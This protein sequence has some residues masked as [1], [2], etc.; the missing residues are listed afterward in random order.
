MLYKIPIEM[1]D[2]RA[3]FILEETHSALSRIIGEGPIDE[4]LAR[5]SEHMGLTEKPILKTKKDRYH[6]L[7]QLEEDFFVQHIKENYL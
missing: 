5:L 7:F 6:L 4:Q 1:P 3:K 2:E